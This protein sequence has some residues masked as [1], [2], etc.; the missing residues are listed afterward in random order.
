M[1]VKPLS[2]SVDDPASSEPHRPFQS[3]LDQHWLF[4]RPVSFHIHRYP[5]LWGGAAFLLGGKLGLRAADHQDWWW[6]GCGLAA[7]IAVALA[8]TLR[9]PI[10]GDSQ[11]LVRH[12]PCR[13]RDRRE[14]DTG[15]T[16]FVVGVRCS[17]AKADCRPS[18][19]RGSRR[20][21]AQSE[22]ST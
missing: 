8:A 19:H 3:W 20:L 6:L 7:L 15:G 2:Q 9:K 10:V 21:D 12:V 13:G 18:H 22:P 17:T 11:R 5:M 1:S 16:G 14:R 4:G